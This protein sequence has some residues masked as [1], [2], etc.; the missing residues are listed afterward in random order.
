MLSLLLLLL[1]R[2]V[3]TGCCEQGWDLG[4]DGVSCL[5]EVCSC[6]AVVRVSQQ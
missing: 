2:L 6:L 3:E 1:L 5:R 4:C